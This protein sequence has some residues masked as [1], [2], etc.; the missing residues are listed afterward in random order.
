MAKPKVSSFDADET[1][2]ALINGELFEQI[3]IIME[4]KVAEN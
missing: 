1:E 3:L 4:S 2:L